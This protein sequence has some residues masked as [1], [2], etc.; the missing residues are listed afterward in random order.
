MSDH[1]KALR[2]FLSRVKRIGN[3]EIMAEGA[4]VICVRDT[5]PTRF[6]DNAKGTCRECGHGVV[7]RPYLPAAAPKMC[8]VCFEDRLT[9]G[10]A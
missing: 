6:T 4:V 8:E 2:D 7:Y 3:D 5:S 9:G 1:R 10:T